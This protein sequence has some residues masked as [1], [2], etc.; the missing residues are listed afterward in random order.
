MGVMA[1]TRFQGRYVHNGESESTLE[2]DM[3]AGSY[4]C[5]YQ[6]LTKFFKPHTQEFD[7]E[8]I[9]GEQRLSFL[10]LTHLLVVTNASTKHYLNMSKGIKVMER[11]RFWLQGR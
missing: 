3:P 8:I 11:T 4:L 10:H 9:S 2:H 1:C 6:T 5:L 7:L